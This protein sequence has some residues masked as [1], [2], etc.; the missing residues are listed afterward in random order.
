MEQLIILLCNPGFIESFVLKKQRMECL[1]CSQTTVE[2]LYHFLCP[3]SASASVCLF[4]CVQM[5]VGIFLCVAGKG[6]SSLRKSFNVLNCHNL[7]LT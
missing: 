5:R 4:V 6:W 7:E 2:S 1:L 3:I